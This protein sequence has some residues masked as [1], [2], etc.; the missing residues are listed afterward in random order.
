[1]QT[2]FPVIMGHVPSGGST[3]TLLHYVQ[4]F[5][6]G[7]FRQYDL[8]VKRNMLRYGQPSPPAYNISMVDFPVAISFGD[9]DWLDSK[10]V[11]ALPCEDTQTNY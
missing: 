2:M 3:R 1:M 9:N 5:T 11:S 8:G 10:E 4:G 7:D 6:S